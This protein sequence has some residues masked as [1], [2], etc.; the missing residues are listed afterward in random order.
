MI[1]YE[2]ELKIDCSK[3]FGY[4]CAAL[5]FSKIDGFPYNK[6]N[7][8][9]CIHLMEHFKC[10]I[11]TS[12][13]DKGLKGCLAYDCFGAGQK[14]AQHTFSNKADYLIDKQYV[15]FLM[16]R[17]LHEI[18]WYLNE[19]KQLTTKQEELIQIENIMDKIHFISLQAVDTLLKNDINQIREQ[20]NLILRTISDNTRNQYKSKFHSKDYIGKDFKKQKIYGVDFRGALLIA[21]NLSDCEL[22]GCDFIGA[23]LRDTNIKGANLSQS[24]FLTQLQIN[25]ACGD[26]KTILPKALQKPN[27]W[28]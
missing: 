10:E 11:H 25:E 23:D 5:Y 8:E 28:D 1:D 15:A 14:V 21:A 9:P 20:V 26:E 12:L 2:N 4:C 3:C 16:M 13:K 19:A 27:H 18:L 22:I 17:S 24:I 7:N 6:K